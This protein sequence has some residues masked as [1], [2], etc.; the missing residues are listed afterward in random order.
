[1]II[2][3]NKDAYKNKI[4]INFKMLKLSNILQIFLLWQNP[5]NTWN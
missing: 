3:N 1:M 2:K 5:N 4:K